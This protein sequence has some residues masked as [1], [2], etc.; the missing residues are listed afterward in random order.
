M[1]SLRK[2]TYDSQITDPFLPPCQPTSMFIR[3][4]KLRAHTM[5]C[6]PRSYPIDTRTTIEFVKTIVPRSMLLP[7]IALCDVL[8][9]FV[10]IMLLFTYI[11]LNLTGLCS[12]DIH[13]ALHPPTASIHCAVFLVVTVCMSIY[14]FTR[15]T[16]ALAHSFIHSFAHSFI[17]SSFSLLP[18][19]PPL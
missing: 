17:R 16:R 5:Y 2:V 11:K 8:S 1:K 7:A 18:S 14:L 4:D 3:D 13:L 12:C 15:G 9:F 6:R 19:P 10:K